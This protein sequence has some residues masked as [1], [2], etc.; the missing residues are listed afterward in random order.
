MRPNPASTTPLRRLAFRVVAVVSVLVPVW[1]R[2]EWRRE[3]EAELW[4][5]GR[6]LVRRS[7]GAIP[8]ALWLRQH[9]WSLDMLMQDL[10]YGARMLRRGPAFTIV[11]SITLALGIGANAVVFSIVNTV[12]WR[13]LPF[14]NAGEL[15][16]L[17]E[18]N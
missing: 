17:W 15:V 4:Y 9:H 2:A 18:T 8:H 12:L 14:P 3:W 5:A 11:A 13:P 7:T 1:R 6:H 16:Q 10:R